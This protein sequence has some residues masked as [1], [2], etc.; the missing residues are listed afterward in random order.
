[1]DELAAKF[2][3]FCL[4]NE[5]INANTKMK[6]QCS[7]GHQ[8]ETES[9]SIK[10]RGSWCPIC[11]GSAGEQ[12][13]QKVLSELG[14]YCLLL[15]GLY[16]QTQEPRR[17][18]Y[19]LILPQLPKKRYDFVFNNY[20]LEFDGQQHFYYCNYF[21]KTIDEFECRQETDILKTKVAIE[22]G[23]NVI[24]IDYENIFNI[25]EII[26]QAIDSKKKLYVSDEN[27]YQWLL[28]EICI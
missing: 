6:W 11:K 4:D 16:G 14:Y 12:L 19:Q 28:K 8:F 21:H 20:I 24:R 17:D 10:N 2:N 26:K 5:Y 3:G 18:K 1:M 25:K 22:S 23:Y 7:K 9:A 27:K 13:C 15:F